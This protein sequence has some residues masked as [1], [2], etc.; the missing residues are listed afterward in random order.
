MKFNIQFTDISL[1]ALIHGMYILRWLILKLSGTV[2]TID[3]QPKCGHDVGF[4]L[5]NGMYSTGI[6]IKHH[7][8]RRIIIDQIATFFFAYIS[9]SIITQT[10]IIPLNLRICVGYSRSEHLKMKKN[11]GQDCHP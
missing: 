7:V 3:L 8:M 9:L 4:W 2:V 10:M 6:I 1:P 11:V 5:E